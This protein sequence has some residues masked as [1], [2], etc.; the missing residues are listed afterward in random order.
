MFLNQLKLNEKEVF[1]N[2]ANILARVDGQ[3]TA[4]EEEMLERI[5]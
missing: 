3:F 1:W 4:E 5:I 2:V